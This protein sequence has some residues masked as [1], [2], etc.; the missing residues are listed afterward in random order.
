M[1]IFTLIGTWLT[2]DA[3]S[4]ADKPKKCIKDGVDMCKYKNHGKMISRFEDI[5]MQYPDIAKVA[6]IIKMK[7]LNTARSISLIFNFLLSRLDPS[8]HL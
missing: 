6:N 7:I 8:E 5:E 2:F 1:R 4:G 3:I